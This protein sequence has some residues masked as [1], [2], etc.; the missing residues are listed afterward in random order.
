MS[1]ANVHADLGIGRHRIDLCQVYAKHLDICG[2][3]LVSGRGRDRV[4]TLKN[5]VGVSRA[6]LHGT[7]VKAFAP[8][9]VYES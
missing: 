6:S 4:M 9:V 2:I 5:A 7:S 8:G 3:I 1:E